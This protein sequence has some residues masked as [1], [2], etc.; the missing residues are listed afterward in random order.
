MEAVDSLAALVDRVDVLISVCPPAEAPTVADA[1]ARAGFAGIY[2]DV[3]AISPAST[4]AIAARFEH[5]VDGGVIGPPVNVAGSTRL[6]LAGAAAADVAELWAG[7]A[8][9]ARVIEGGIGA[10]SAVKVCFAAWTKGTAALLLA[11]RALANAEGVEQALLAEWSTSIPGLAEQADRAAA[12]NSAKA[13]RFVGEMEEIADSFAA[14]GLPV[15]FGV[16]AA[17]IYQR[18]AEFKDTSAT[19]LAEVIDALLRSD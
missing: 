1:V 8:L 9:E 11:I 7:S 6:Y 3:N 19:A 12:A 15:G 10:A 14:H 18:M 5:F 13:W 4:R 17:D 16:A 2:V